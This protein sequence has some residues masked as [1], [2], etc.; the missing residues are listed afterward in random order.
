MNK[1]KH[2]EEGHPSIPFHEVKRTYVRK[3]K[4]IE[5]IEEVISSTFENPIVSNINE[6][7][8]PN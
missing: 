6:P 4:S 1:G 5:E 8:N 2:P 3:R 7:Q